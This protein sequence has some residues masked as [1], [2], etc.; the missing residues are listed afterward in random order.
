MNSRDPNTIFIIIP[1]YPLFVW[2]E[3]GI[4]LRKKISRKIPLTEFGLGAYK[5]LFS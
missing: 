3:D 4:T 1:E 5:Y 2:H